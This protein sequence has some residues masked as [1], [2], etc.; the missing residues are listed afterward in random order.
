MSQLTPD[1]LETLQPGE[2]WSIAG[3][4]RHVGGAEWWYLDRLGLA[5]PREDVPSEP[6]DRLD[7]VRTSLL[8]TL[9]SLIGSQQVVGKDGEF[10]SPRKL[11]RRAAW[12]ERDHILHIQK[13]LGL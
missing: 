9:L 1:R 7:K 13:L 2:R 10:W 12:H 5:T 6:F 11:L 3:I 4:L 8:E